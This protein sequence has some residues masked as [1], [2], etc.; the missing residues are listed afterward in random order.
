MPKKKYF[1]NEEKTEILELSWKSGYSEIE[2][3][4]NSKSV[5]RM[6]GGQAESG[7]QIELIDGKKLYVKLERSFFP[8]LI[9]KIDGKHVSGTHGDPVYQ[10]RQIFY[11]MIV[12]GIVN[13]LIEL[14]IFIMG[15]E[16]YNLKYCTAALGII[17]IVLGYLVSKGNGIALTAIILLLFCDLIISMKTIPVM[18]SIVLVM[19]VAFL[20][21]IIRGFRYIKEY[22]AEKA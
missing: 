10:L 7:Q 2:I 20:A 12:L 18:S 9:V 15:F 5:A 17:Y 6:S 19:K 4:Y 14:F 21:I 1:L 22:N 16:I 13:I 3:F 8:V 11:F